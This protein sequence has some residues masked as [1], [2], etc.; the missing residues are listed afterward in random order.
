MKNSNRFTKV[1]PEE[2]NDQ[3]MGQVVSMPHLIEAVQFNLMCMEAEVIDWI[4]D[5]LDIKTVED[6]P[7]VFKEEG[8]Q[9][10]LEKVVTERLGL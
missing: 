5:N 1:I 8:W 9:K 2:L 4:V 3:E 6:I 10:E 7:Q